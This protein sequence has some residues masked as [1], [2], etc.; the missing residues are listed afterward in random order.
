MNNKA[1]PPPA[2]CEEAAQRLMDPIMRLIHSLNVESP[3]VVDALNAAITAQ[4]VLTV[5]CMAAD[6]S[7]RVI[8]QVNAE[9]LK[10]KQWASE[11]A[12]RH[13]KGVH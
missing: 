8:A 12:A 6:A 1:L 2:N 7:K 11:L 9:L 3:L 10:L 13:V 5:Q 4:R